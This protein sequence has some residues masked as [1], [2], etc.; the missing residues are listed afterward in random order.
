MSKKMLGINLKVRDLIILIVVML[1]FM[2]TLANAM[3]M[4]LA[5]KDYQST[6]S[7]MALYE[8]YGSIGLGVV[9]TFVVIFAL[10]IVLRRV[11]RPIWKLTQA[12]KTV[13]AGDLETDIPYVERHDEFGDMAR[14]LQTFVQKLAENERLHVKQ[15]EEDAC[16]AARADKLE[17][18]I[19]IFDARIKDFLADLQGSVSNLSS[20]ANTLGGVAQTSLQHSDTLKTSAEHSADNTNSVANS[21]EQLSISINGV[22][23]QIARSSEVSSRAV[24]KSR[25]ATSAITAL[26]ESAERINGVIELINDIAGQTNMLALNATIEAVRAGEAG[27]SFSVVA[28]EVKSLASQTAEATA[29][30]SEQ[31]ESVKSSVGSTVLVIEEIEAI[32]NDMAQMLLSVSEAMNEQGAATQEIAGGAQNAAQ[33]VQN[34]MGSAESVYNSANATNDESDRLGDISSSL[35]EADI[36]SISPSLS[37]STA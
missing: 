29:E 9:S 15:R 7:H 32:I 22:T 28:H 6:A 25:E 30:I 4:L 16:R 19:N 13:S 14:T 2:G 12:M 34:V 11:A 3:L 36:T 10:V 37:K 23:Q 26:Q 21:A 18:G 1:A 8:L 17:S 5:W 27:K 33:G 35:S 24:E 20:A 31:V